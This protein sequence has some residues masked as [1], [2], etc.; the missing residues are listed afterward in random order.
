MNEQ[1][2]GREEKEN[3]LMIRNLVTRFPLGCACYKAVFDEQ[4]MIRDYVIIGINAL[5]EKI[6]GAPRTAVVGKTISKAFP[7]VNSKSIEYI[8]KLGNDALRHND[9]AFAANISVFNHAYKTS[10]FFISEAMILGIYEDMHAQF[11]RK[12]CRRAIPQ[13]VIEKSLAERAALFKDGSPANEDN[14]DDCLT[15]PHDAETTLARKGPLVIMPVTCDFSEPYDAVFRDSL[16]GLYD[17]FFGMETLKMYIEH[18]A[19]P[20]SVAFG[21]VNGLN[22]INEALGYRNGDE[23]LIKIA[24]ILL[25]DRLREDIVVRWNDDAF[26]LVLPYTTREEVQ[27]ILARLQEK[28]RGVCGENCVSVTFGYATAENA[29]RKAEDLVREAEKWTFR[30]K[31]LV[32]QSHRSSIIRLL[33]STLH[34]K[35]ADTQEH[36]GRM[37]EHCRWIAEQLGLSDELLNDLLLLAMLHDIGKVAIS[38]EILNKPG[39]LTDEERLIINKHPEIGYRITRT[40]PELLQVSDYILAH[41]ERWDGGGYPKGLKGEE[42]PIASRII[43]V[44]DTFDVIVSGRAYRAARS[45]AE[46]IAELRRCRGTQF[47]PKVVDIYIRLLEN[48]R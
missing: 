3:L 6:C 10:F 38:H 26:M 17:R 14:E 21:D 5:F 33:L 46:A 7:K 29:A 41:H 40:V 9:K 13:E 20:L 23:L 35:S 34:E 19:L 27:M 43:A 4:G 24:R 39:P 16:T 11:L 48:R 44:V 36:S 47:D 25:E 15:K 12:Y 18:G 8:I 1:R 42:I 31:L 37:A 2:I 22:T 45:E 32:S 30:K 28:L